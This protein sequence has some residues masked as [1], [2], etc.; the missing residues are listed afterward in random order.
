MPALDLTFDELEVRYGSTLA[1]AYLV[2]I[3]KSAAIPS[4]QMADLD[5]EIRLV[6]AFRAQQTVADTTRYVQPG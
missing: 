3:E 5:P 4:A 2:E 6:N 1:H